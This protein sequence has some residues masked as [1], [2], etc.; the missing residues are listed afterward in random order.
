[1]KYRVAFYLKSRPPEEVFMIN[2]VPK[3]PPSR[4]PGQAALSLVNAQWSG[5][6]GIRE[7]IDRFDVTSIKESGREITPKTSAP[8]SLGSEF[9][10][11]IRME[12]GIMNGFI[13]DVLLYQPLDYPAL[14]RVTTDRRLAAFIKTSG[15]INDLED[16]FRQISI[17]PYARPGNEIFALKGN[18]LNRKLK[19]H[20]KAWLALSNDYENDKPRKNLADFY[21]FAWRYES[22]NILSISWLELFLIAEAGL[23]VKNC[24]KCGNYYVPWPPNALNCS[25]CKKEYTS[26]ALYRERKKDERE[27]KMKTMTEEEKMEEI[28]KERAWRRDY[29]QTYRKNKNLERKEAE[30]RKEEKEE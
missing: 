16:F 12:Q 30:K 24:R 27:D 29:M 13:E 20:E 17:L 26:Q 28:E 22:E 9:E 23:K 7:F 15:N 21:F 1:M 10:L 25:I 11:R 8:N 6:K 4:F 18:D 3:K 2:Q 5:E 14:E 19:K